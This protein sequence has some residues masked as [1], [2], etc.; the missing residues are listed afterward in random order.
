MILRRRNYDYEKRESRRRKMRNRRAGGK[1]K[2]NWMR[3]IRIEEKETK[4]KER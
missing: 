2:R 1:S 3:N 4:S